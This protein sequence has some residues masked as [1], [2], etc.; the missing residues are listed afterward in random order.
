MSYA[1]QSALL[2][3]PM[4]LLKTFLSRSAGEISDDCVQIWGGRGIT[5]GGM[6]ALIEQFQRTYKV[7]SRSL[8][9]SYS[10]D[11][12]KS[13]GADPAR[14]SFLLAVRLDPRRVRGGARRLGRPAGDEAHAAGRALMR[15]FS[16]PSFVEPVFVF[17]PGAQLAAVLSAGPDRARERPA[18]TNRLQFLI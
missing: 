18:S 16:S 14:T 9:H 3:G 8:S 6:G 12:S 7:R 1:D 13:R 5:Q 10:R 4:A 11:V 17:R 2:A 15:L